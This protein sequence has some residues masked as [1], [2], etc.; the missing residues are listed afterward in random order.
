MTRR[1]RIQAARKTSR[2]DHSR[3][4]RRTCPRLAEQRSQA[5]D[6]R[7]SPDLDDWQMT[8]LR[9]E[10][11]LQL[12]SRTSAALDLGGRPSTGRSARP[13]PARL[14][15]RR[16]AGRL[17]FAIDL[18]RD[19]AFQEI[20]RPKPVVPVE[21][22]RELASKRV[23]SVGDKQSTRALFLHRSDQSL[24]DGDAAVLADGAE[25]LPDVP[26]PA[27]LSEPL[28]SELRPTVRDQMPRA[29]V[30]GAQ[31]SS[32]NGSDRDRRR[33]L[34]E[35]SEAHDPARV[36]IDDY[37]DP[38]AERPARWQR[39]GQPGC[40]EPEGGRDDTQIA[41]PDVIGPLRTNGASGR[42][43]HG[44]RVPTGRLFPLPVNCRG[45]DVQT[46]PRQDLGCFD[47]AQS[48][49][50]HLEALD[51]VGDEFGELVDRYPDLHECSGSVFVQPPHPRG[52]G[53]GRDQQM[54]GR[55]RQ[56][57]CPCRAQ[58]ENRQPFGRWVVRPALGR[59]SQHPRVLDPHLFPDQGQLLSQSVV[60]SLEPD[61]CIPVVGGPTARGSQRE[62]GQGDGVDHGRLDLAGPAPGKGNS[63][64]R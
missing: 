49:T 1:E 3:H 36:V 12:Q 26:T 37:G 45:S 18:L 61:P 16:F 15:S 41:M 24:D 14:D 53:G 23:V 34:L 55:L 47:P 5:V 4:S 39:E 48:G 9:E 64:W 20:M 51:H 21:V 59:D 52:N 7:C 46:R 17:D 63:W 22:E 27:P 56:R 42:L 19:R 8:S 54:P 50:Q 43:G 30:R 40:P 60:L 33:L 38:P 62:V 31:G 29:S 44:R 13:L 35:P 32:K 58:L 28:V 57:P 11:D 2:R 10:A 25:A 6:L